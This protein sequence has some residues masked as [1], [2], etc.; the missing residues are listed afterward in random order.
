MKCEYCGEELP[1]A[2]G[3][4]ND[5]NTGIAIRFVAYWHQCPLFARTLDTWVQA[6]ADKIDRRLEAAERHRVELEL[7][8]MNDEGCPNG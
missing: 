7:A 3:I 2:P 1:P 8:R 4:A 6:I 5:P